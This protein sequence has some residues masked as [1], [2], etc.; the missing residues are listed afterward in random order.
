M[1]TA[2]KPVA[3]TL[4]WGIGCYE[5]TARE[6]EPVAEQVVQ[7]ARLEDRERL[8]DIGCGTGN[9]ALLAARSGAR[10]TGVDPAPRLISVARQRAITEH[11]DASFV[12]GG[13]EDLPFAGDSFDVAVSVFGIVFADDAERAFAEMMR[14]LRVGGRALISAWSPDGAIHRMLGALGEALKEATGR[15]RRRFPWH[16]PDAFRDLASGYRVAIESHEGRIA[17][18][19]SSPSEFFAHGE[20]NHPMNLAAKPVLDRAGSYAAARERAIAVLEGANEAREGF[21]VTSRYRVFELT[22]VDR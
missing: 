18:T 12:V 19:G 13:A 16:D 11:L 17:F 22:L 7:L 5:E 21:R 1:S 14:V 4:D 15:E 6:L 20:A 3:T 8:L 2:G 10:A 9:A